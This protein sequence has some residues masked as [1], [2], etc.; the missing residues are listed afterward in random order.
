FYI[1]NPA[2]NTD[3]NGSIV[4]SLLE[5]KNNRL[6]IATLRGGLSILDIKTNKFIPI[7]EFSRLKG[8]YALELDKHG[9]IWVGHRIGITV[10]DSQFNIKQ[11]LFP[12]EHERSSSNLVN[13]ILK[14]V[15]GD[16]WVGTSNGLFRYEKDGTSY[17]QY[18]YYHHDQDSSSIS[19]NYIRSIGQ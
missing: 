12:N 14:D 11:H 17:K 13:V 6:W 2:I 8:A 3:L 9:D 10:F 18:S 1:D 7:N 19:G 16:M 4:M 5:D 15:K